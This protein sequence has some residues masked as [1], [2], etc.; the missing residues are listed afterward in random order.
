MRVDHFSWIV[1]SSGDDS[2][3]PMSPLYSFS[4]MDILS[5]FPCSDDSLEYQ[6][7]QLV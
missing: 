4:Q 2:H 6:H 5:E 7:L 3:G 1:S